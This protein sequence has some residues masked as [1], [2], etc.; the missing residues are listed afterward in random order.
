MKIFC[1][2]L[3]REDLFWSLP[4]FTGKIAQEAIWC[5]IFQKGA[6]EQKR[7]KTLDLIN[8]VTKTW[9]KANLPILSKQKIEAKVK[10][11]ISHFEAARKRVKRRKS[12][13]VKRAS[14]FVG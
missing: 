13:E 7:L 1:F 11:L 2:G 10:S 3:G 6:I 9:N 5:H 8:D 12:N 14:K 4:H